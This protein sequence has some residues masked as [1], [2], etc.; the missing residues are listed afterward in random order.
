LLVLKMHERLAADRRDLTL[1]LASGV[2]I[3][4]GGQKAYQEWL[5]G[6]A[7]PVAANAGAAARQAA[8]I[9]RL[10]SLFAHQ[11]PDAIRKKPD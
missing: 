1:T 11:F 2:G 10:Q 4:M 6:Q 8:T 3:G 9:G 5:R 7:A